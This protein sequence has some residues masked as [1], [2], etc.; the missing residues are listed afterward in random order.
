[1]ECTKTI[2][3]GLLRALVLA[4]IPM[5]ALAEAPPVVV[6]AAVSQSGD[7]ADLASDFRK[8][9]LLWQ[10]DVNAAGGLLGRHV[11]LLLVDDRSEANRASALYTRLIRE[12]KADLLIGPFGSAATV[13]AAAAAER[14]S[15]VLL[16]ATGATQSV[17]RAGQ[18]YVFQVAA[19][20][21]VYGEELLGLLR[22]AG[23]TKLSVIARDDPASREMAQ[24]FVERAPRFGLAPGELGVYAGATRDFTSLVQAARAAS[25]DAWIAFGGETDAAE[26]VKAMKRAGYAP[27]LFFARGAADARFIGEVGQDAE[28]SMAL[29]AYEPGFTTPGNALF[30]QGYAAKWSAAPTLAAA[31]AYAAGQVLEQAVRKAGSLDQ[32]KL[33]AALASLEGGTVLGDY[34]I[35]PTT[36]EQLGARPPVV[37]VLEGQ[38]RAVWPRTQ[39][40]ARWRLPYPRWDER[41][42]IQ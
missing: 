16:N 31:Q 34:R 3:M 14:N 10:D 15:R 11:E 7:L 39:A 4:L 33:R 42:P 30:V 2:M 13:G 41:K 19:P 36:G 23:Y 38:P 17:L 5:W 22:A 35:D 37:Q 24:S 9:L 20:Y 18:R 27:K 32:E 8:G 25:P 29:S 12:E 40:T 1:M 26:M 28:F 21:A 6:G